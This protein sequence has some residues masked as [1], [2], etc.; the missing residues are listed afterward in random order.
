MNKHL[1]AFLVSLFT[2]V[3][4]ASAQSDSQ[5]MADVLGKRLESPSEIAFQLR[6]YLM[7]RVAKLAGLT[8]RRNGPRKRNVSGNTSW[9]TSCFTAGRRN[10]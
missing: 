10:G 5:R 9:K 6:E 3:L 8:T 7:D 1:I 4:I 2:T